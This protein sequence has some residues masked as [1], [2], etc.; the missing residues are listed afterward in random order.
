MLYV[1]SRRRVKAAVGIADSAN[2]R[3]EHR[4]KLFTELKIE[5]EGKCEECGR[6]WRR[7]E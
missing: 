1:I 2:P 7:H 4:R 5:G 6:E 3:G